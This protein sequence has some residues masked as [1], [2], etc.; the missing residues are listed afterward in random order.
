M[1]VV[2]LIVTSFLGTA[3]S[4]NYLFG[5]A[6]IIFF[7]EDSVAVKVLQKSSLLVLDDYV[8]ATYPFSSTNITVPSD[9]EKIDD[10]GKSM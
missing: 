10:L 9:V 3:R 2:S 8:D 4:A 5:H 6:T 1:K 7:D